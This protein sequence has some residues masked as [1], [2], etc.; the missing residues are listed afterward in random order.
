MHPIRGGFRDEPAAPECWGCCGSSLEAGGG[1][2]PPGKHQSLLSGTCHCCGPGGIHRV[3]TGFFCSKKPAMH[4]VVLKAW[5]DAGIKSVFGVVFSSPGSPR[6]LLPDVFGQSTTPL[7]LPH[8]QVL[9]C[10]TG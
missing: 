9:L 8:C 4:P 2:S 6:E 7:S 1:F 3:L 10:V 5:V